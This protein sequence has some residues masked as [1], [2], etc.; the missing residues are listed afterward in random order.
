MTQNNDTLK[1]RYT[2]IA[3]VDIAVRYWVEQQSGGYTPGPWVYF[4][5][6]PY[7]QSESTSYINSV[8]LNLEDQL[9]NTIDISF[10]QKF[11]NDDYVIMSDPVLRYSITVDDAIGGYVDSDKIEKITLY[12]DGMVTYY[13]GVSEPL[14]LKVLEIVPDKQYIIDVNAEY[15]FQLDIKDTTLP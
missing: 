6:L 12:T 11:Q 4:R 13:Q 10:C 5:V 15:T 3:Y 1:T 2:E 14:T 8:V 9:I 7:L